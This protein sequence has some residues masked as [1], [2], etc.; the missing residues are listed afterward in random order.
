[1]NEMSR[2][3]YDLRNPACRANLRRRWRKGCRWFMF[4]LA[5]KDT[6]GKVCS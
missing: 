6:L 3:A 1:V 4:K 2:E 5:V